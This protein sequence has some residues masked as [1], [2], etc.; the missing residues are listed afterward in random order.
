MIICGAPY[1]CLEL[2]IIYTGRFP[3][4]YISAL[5]GGAAV[6]P[7]SIDPWIFLL[8][9]VNWNEPAD[10]NSRA[11]RLIQFSNHQQQ[12]QNPYHYAKRVQ[13]SNTLCS[14]SSSEPYQNH[15]QRNSAAHLSPLTCQTKRLNRIQERASIF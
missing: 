14:S 2:Y 5:A 4:V 1:Y 8:F 11:Q 9:W 6:A 10:E 7:S 13:R 15:L 12:Q 3:S